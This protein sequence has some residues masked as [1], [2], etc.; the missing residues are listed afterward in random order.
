M[1]KWFLEGV[2]VIFFKIFFSLKGKT[3]ITPILEQTIE[4]YK[5]SGFTELFTRIRLWD[6]PISEI[7]Q[8]VSK[9]GIVVDLGCGDG[10]LVNYLSLASKKRIVYGIELNPGRIKLADK[11]LK[12]SHFLAGDITQRKVP[13]ADIILLIHVL[14]HL[15]SFEEQEK[16]LSMCFQKLNPGGK[17]IISEIDEQPLIKYWF[18][19]ITDV[20]IVPVL[21]ENK[22]FNM[23]IYYRTCQEWK[24]LLKK[25]GFK[26][27]SY[28]AHKGKPFSHVMI[29][30]EKL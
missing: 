25:I 7:E 17:L 14:H 26:T 3:D 5:G 9:Q 12:N 2:L 22:L 20:V 30:C 19:W 6:S 4:L 29:I 1:I 16:L 23:A 11:G 15:N 8:I 10:L 13:K 27:S 28:K 24:I 21:F 18:T